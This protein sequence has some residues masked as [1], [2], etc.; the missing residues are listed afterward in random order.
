M[1]LALLV[2][3]A[4]GIGGGLL[5]GGDDLTGS[6]DPFAGQIDRNSY[7]AVILANDRVYFGRI[8]NANS[9]FYKLEDAFF[10]RESRPD[11]EAEPVRALLEVNREIHGPRNEMLIRKS[12]V[13]LVEDLADDS[14]ILREIKR[15]KENGTSTTAP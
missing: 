4:L 1:L 3:L 10:L 15:Q 14:P 8:S 13:V 11:A 2:G 6:D 5:F 7:Q 9:D 12:E